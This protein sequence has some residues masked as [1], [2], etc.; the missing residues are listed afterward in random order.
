MRYDILG[1]AGPS[2][3]FVVNADGELLA[4][5]GGCTVW[6]GSQARDA[7]ENEQCRQRAQAFCVLLNTKLKPG[8][9]K[10]AEK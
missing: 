8:A 10:K 2:R 6:K 5:F 9:K 7:A 3:Y 1:L 4:D